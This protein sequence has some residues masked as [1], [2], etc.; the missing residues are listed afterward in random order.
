MGRDLIENSDLHAFT[1][2]RFQN[3][4][5]Y[6]DNTVYLGFLGIGEGKV[7]ASQIASEVVKLDSNNTDFKAKMVRI[8][9][10]LTGDKQAVAVANQN[11][12][13]PNGLEIVSQINKAFAVPS[14]INGLKSHNAYFDVFYRYY[15]PTGKPLDCSSLYNYLADLETEIEAA[16]LK[17]S[18]GSSV[19]QATLEALTTKRAEIKKM[20]NSQQCESKLEQATSEKNRQQTLSDLAAATKTTASGISPTLKYIIIGAGVIAIIGTVILL[21]K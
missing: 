10:T 16:N 18:S 6:N 17:G 8:Y 14:S 20:M 4:S 21:K 7:K 11:I 2:S 13:K 15:I 9:N 1:P 19:T 5:F 12:N 3:K